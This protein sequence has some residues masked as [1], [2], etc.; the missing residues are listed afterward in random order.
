MQ[1]QT[2]GAKKPLWHWSQV[3]KAGEPNYEMMHRECF[4][5]VGAILLLRPYLVWQ[6]FTICKDHDV[7]EWIRNLADSTVRL[8][9]T[10]RQVENPFI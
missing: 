5:V 6:T 2:D 1:D 4:T 7:L 9:S 3:L 10:T 8:A